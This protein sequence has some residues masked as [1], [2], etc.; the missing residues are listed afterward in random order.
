MQ[1]CQID[2]CQDAENAKKEGITVT[3]S[4]L[5]YEV[6]QEGAGKQPKATDTVRCHY[7]GR[8]AGTSAGDLAT[9][10]FLSIVATS[11]FSLS[12]P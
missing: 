3:K 7:E 6:L 8:P 12:G 4:G 9:A 10:W 1:I 2:C 5:Q 11:C